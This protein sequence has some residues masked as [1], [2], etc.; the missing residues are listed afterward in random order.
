M[1]AERPLRVLIVDDHD[2]VRV[3]VRALLGRLQRRCEIADSASLREALARLQRE[4]VDLLLLDLS[5]GDEF[6]LAS[7]PR[8]REAGGSAM[9][10]LVLSSLAENLYAEHCLRAGADGYVMKSA[11]SDDLVQAVHAVL[12]GQ[13]YL[14]AAQR[15]AL[16]RQS[17]GRGGRTHNGPELS[18]REIEVLR[19]VAAGR[20]TREIA[21]AL[22]RSVKTIESHKLSLKTKLDADTPSMLVRKAVAWLE[23]Q[24]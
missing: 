21:E 4:P 11:L 10:I 20:S 17:I 9:K 19:L 15:D 1:S 18:S 5:L 13:V 3:G 12:A 23:A 14:S 16:L 2:V 24:D 6:A 7:V 8:L 22:N